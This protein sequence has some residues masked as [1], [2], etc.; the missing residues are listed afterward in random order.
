MDQKK[1]DTMGDNTGP[2]AD[3]DFYFEDEALLYPSFTTPH[4]QYPIWR[5]QYPATTTLTPRKFV[6][7][8]SVTPFHDEPICDMVPIIKGSYSVNLS[9]GSNGTGR[10]SNCTL[11][12]N[13]LDSCSSSLA[14]SMDS[15]D[16]D[17]GHML[18]DYQDSFDVHA[19]KDYQD[20]INVHASNEED[21]NEKFDHCLRPLAWAIS[22]IQ[23]SFKKIRS[24]QGNDF[25]NKNRR[26]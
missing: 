18:V 22:L 24:T 21:A 6:F 4:K 20:S 9:P 19:S 5:K 14:Y 16:M 23:Q 10:T 8:P 3:Y 2:N 1:I 26:P 13:D 11:E 15:A 7:R 12:D 25:N 17:M